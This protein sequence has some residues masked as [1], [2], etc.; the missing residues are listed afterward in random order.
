MQFLHY[1]YYY[2]I[3]TT[4]AIICMVLRLLFNTLLSTIHTSSQISSA[5]QEANLIHQNESD[6]MSQLFNFVW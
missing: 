4:L 6:S 5:S 2:L 1:C 3:T